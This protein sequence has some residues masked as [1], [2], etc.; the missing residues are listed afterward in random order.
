ML[1]EKKRPGSG[2]S[3]SEPRSEDDR[4]NPF[5]PTA[6]KASPTRDG[7]YR[8]EEGGRYLYRYGPTARRSTISQNSVV[9]PPHEGA[10]YEEVEAGPKKWQQHRRCERCRSEYL[11]TRGGQSYCSPNCRREAAY[12]R[13]RFNSQTKGP[14]KR[15]L[16]PRE[17]SETCAPTAPRTP[18][19]MGDTG[20]L[21]KGGY[22]L[23]K[24]RSL[25]RGIWSP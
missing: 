15:L 1:P 13:E 22:F 2:W 24:N 9:G 10:G 6:T 19:G 4:T 23:N 16:R 18:P 5:Y 3:R 7:T 8:Y 12:G 11:Q 14:R 21:P 25:Q 20:K 17:A